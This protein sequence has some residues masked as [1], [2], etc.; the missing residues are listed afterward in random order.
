MEGAHCVYYHPCGIHVGA[1]RVRV[2]DQMYS[3]HVRMYTNVYVLQ[4]IHLMIV[5]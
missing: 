4:Y 5:L 2:C 3:C 1:H